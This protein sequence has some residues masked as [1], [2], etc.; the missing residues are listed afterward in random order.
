MDGRR[1][2]MV[3][4]GLNSVPF[5]KHPFSKSPMRGNRQSKEYGKLTV[6]QFRQLLAGLSELR[7]LNGE[8]QDAVRSAP[9]ERLDEL[10]R[11]GCSWAAVYEL[12]FME[13]LAWLI[14][15]LDK[16]E[17]LKRAVQSDDPQQVVLDDLKNEDSEEWQGGFQ[18]LFTK[19]DLIGLAVSVQKSI[20]SLMTYQKS[21]SA[22]VREAGEGD[23]RA[24][25][26]AVRIDR[27]IMA[28]PTI[29]DR[30]ARAEFAGDEQFFINLRN[31]LK[32]PDAKHWQGQQ[33]V[34]Y[35]FA[36]LREVGFDK[37]TDEQLETLFVD[38]LQIYPKTPTARQNLRQQYRVSKKIKNLK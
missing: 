1:A 23:D 36:V 17:F 26:N 30:I 31:A 9:K 25:F 29:A 10:L 2:A 21:L 8:L 16:G 19:Q 12:P 18:G 32:G 3:K 24:L 38:Q 27:S 20:V 13:H 34:R 33:D 7:K 35:A 5:L 14:I 11:V 4:T 37:L 6:E 15:A 28:C 22:L